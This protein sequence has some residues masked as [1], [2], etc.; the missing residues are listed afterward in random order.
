MNVQD[1]KGR[2]KFK[3][4]QFLGYV[5]W[6]QL[7]GFHLR[8]TSIGSKVHNLQGKIK[9]EAKL[10]LTKTIRVETA[11][12]IKETDEKSIEWNTSGQGQL[13]G[14]DFLTPGNFTLELRINKKKVSFN[15]FKTRKSKGFY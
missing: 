3:A 9:S 4:G 1:I 12:N 14:L 11:D 15:G 2:P 5:F 6:K 8:W 10:K 7:D 13:D